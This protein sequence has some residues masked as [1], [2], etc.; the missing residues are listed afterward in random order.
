MRFFI[1]K[2]LNLRN[3]SRTAVTGG[4]CCFINVHKFHLIIRVDSNSTRKYILKALANIQKAKP[5]SEIERSQMGD[6]LFKSNTSSEKVNR[7]RLIATLSQIALD[8]YFKEHP[9]DS[10]ENYINEAD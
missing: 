9:D 7:D 8:K 5:Y 6:D 3:S 2:P 4:A 1:N 10:I